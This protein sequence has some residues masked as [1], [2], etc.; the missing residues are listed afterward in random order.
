MLKTQTASQR[1]ADRAAQ[2]L[3]TLW[4]RVETGR[5]TE[6]GFKNLAAAVVAQANAQGVNL[7][8]LGVTAEVV[9]QRHRLVRPLGLLPEDVQVDQAHIA[10]ALTRIIGTDHGT[11]AEQ[12]AQSRRQR[13]ARFGSD[14]V[15][16]TVATSTQRAMRAHKAHG[17]V[18]ATDA[19][20][21]PLCQRWAN[22]RTYSTLTAMARHKGC[23][24]IQ[25]PVF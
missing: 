9:R 14:Q 10:A 11:T 8:D 16:L 15:L 1:L 21:C 19:D 13:V 12:V 18:R 20:P 23:S 25:S 3:E 2:R 5:L 4:A 22:G 7:A 17:W 6:T 24:C